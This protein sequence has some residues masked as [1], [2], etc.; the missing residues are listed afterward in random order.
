MRPALSV[1]F[2]D[3][4]F[5]AYDMIKRGDMM[6]SDDVVDIL[7]IPLIGLVPDDENV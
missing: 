3:L 5:H 4:N 7:S 2:G 6:S 1:C